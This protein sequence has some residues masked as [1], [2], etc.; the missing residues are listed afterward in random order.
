MK[1]SVRYVHKLIMQYSKGNC[2]LHGDFCIDPVNLAVKC[3]VGS[4]LTTR[5]NIITDIHYFYNG[6]GYFSVFLLEASVLMNKLIPETHTVCCQC[7]ESAKISPMIPFE[8]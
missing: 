1:K 6:G 2:A 8:R 5:W 4:Q 7:S 3:N